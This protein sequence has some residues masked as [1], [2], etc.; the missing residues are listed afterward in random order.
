MTFRIL[1]DEHV[2]PQTVRYLQ[3]SG[4]E[5][6]H[7]RD[8]RSLG[9]DDAVATYAREHGYSVLTNDRGFLDE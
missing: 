8:V 3:R 5:A 4:H 6:V 9:V 1:C 2:E 7:V